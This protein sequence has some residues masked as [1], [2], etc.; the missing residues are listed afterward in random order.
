MIEIYDKVIPKQTEQRIID[1]VNGKDFNWHMLSD[2]SFEPGLNMPAYHVDKP[3]IAFFRSIYFEGSWDTPELMPWCFQILDSV[4]EQSGKTIN[5]LIRIQFNLL[6]QNPDKSY[7]IDNWNNAHIDQEFDHNVLL[8]YIDDSDGNT[9]VFNERRGDVIENFTIN[10]IIEP[11]RG[12]AILFD[13]NQYHASSNSVK[14]LKRLA[15]N[16][17]FK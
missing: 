2:S 13:G 4:L 15:I 9:F 14:Y 17:N 5:E 10:K 16:F 8:Y 7:T 12:R 11:K 1:I 3:T 6:Y